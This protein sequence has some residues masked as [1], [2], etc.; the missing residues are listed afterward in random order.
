M[1]ELQAT[2]RKWGSSIGIALPKEIVEKANIKPNSKV[3][4]F[5]HDKKVDLS[6]VFGALKIE[7]PTQEILDEMREGEDD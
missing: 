2:A 7:T 6:R 1:I 4:V 3:R 5:I